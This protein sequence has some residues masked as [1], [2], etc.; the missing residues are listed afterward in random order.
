MGAMIAAFVL[1]GLVDLFLI[2]V[3][4]SAF[5]DSLIIHIARALV[6]GVVGL[7]FVGA[8]VNSFATVRSES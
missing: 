8:A 6:S 1:W 3:M 5:G 4:F 7:S 2:A